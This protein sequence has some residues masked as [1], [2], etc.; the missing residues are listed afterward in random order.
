MRRDDRVDRVFAALSDDTR[1]QVLRRL[2][3]GPSSA[4]ELARQLPV[5]R[6]AVSKHLEVLGQA[7]L[8][9]S[10]REGRELLYRLTPGPFAEAMDWMAAVG[11]KWDVRLEALERHLRSG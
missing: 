5:S 1:R 11:S 8:V 6:Q 7:G 3:E 4:S 2:A 9:A 10:A